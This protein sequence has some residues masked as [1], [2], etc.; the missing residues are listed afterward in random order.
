MDV[1]RKMTSTPSKPRNF[2][3]MSVHFVWV[4]VLPLSL[5]WSFELLMCC[6]GNDSC[7]FGSRQKTLSVIGT[8]T[9]LLRW[10]E[11]K[12]KEQREWSCSKTNV[13]LGDYFLGSWCALVCVPFEETFHDAWRTD[14]ARKDDVTTVARLVTPWTPLWSRMDFRPTRFLER[15]S[16]IYKK[17]GR[18]DLSSSTDLGDPHSFCNGPTTTAAAAAAKSLNYEKNE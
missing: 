16:R 7:R 15:T 13:S 18:D 3:T 11:L 2:F 6:I 1:E 10:R 14:L 4:L 17:F 8:H 5:W 9:Q 12:G